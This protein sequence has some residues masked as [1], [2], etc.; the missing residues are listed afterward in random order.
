[1]SFFKFVTEIFLL[2]E[3]PGSKVKKN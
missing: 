2:K 3:N 1:M